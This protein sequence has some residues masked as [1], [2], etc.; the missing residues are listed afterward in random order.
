MRVLKYL[1]VAIFSSGLAL[2]LFWLF[3]GKENDGIF[4]L[5]I[6]LVSIGW[7][8]SLIYHITE[9]RNKKKAKG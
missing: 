5:A 7:L 8:L 2:E 3:S 4:L 1:Y 6:V 9:W